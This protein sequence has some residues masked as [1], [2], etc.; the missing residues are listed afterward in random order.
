MIFGC[1]RP[2][3]QLVYTPL[4][5]RI[6]YQMQKR[7]STGNKAIPSST[8]TGH[9][10]LFY[11]A[12]KPR[13]SLKREKRRRFAFHNSHH[14]AI[15]VILARGDENVWKSFL[16]WLDSGMHYMKR[17]P[18]RCGLLF[19]GICQPWLQSFNSRIQTVSLIYCIHAF[20]TSRSFW[21]E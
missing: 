21:L 18:F 10:G 5:K 12:H 15:S 3:L 17:C 6:R 11:L 2:P 9:S 20:S 14:V 4:P 1:K 7:E 8:M 16:Q 13:N 19:Q